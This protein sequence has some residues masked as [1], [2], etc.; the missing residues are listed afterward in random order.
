MW[1]STAAPLLPLLLLL[2]LS[3]GGSVSVA[4]LA[5]IAMGS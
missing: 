5:E 4:P 1:L 3:L 2:P